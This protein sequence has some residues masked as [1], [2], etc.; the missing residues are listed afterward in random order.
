MT[1][2]IKMPHLSHWHLVFEDF[3]SLY[4]AWMVITR[5]QD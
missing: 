5:Y 4:D 2:P 1:P 3:G